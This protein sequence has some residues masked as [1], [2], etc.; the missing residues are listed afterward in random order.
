MPEKHL[1]SPNVK[2]SMPKVAG[3]PATSARILQYASQHAFLAILTHNP[4]RNRKYVILTEPPRE[5]RPV[6][7]H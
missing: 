6:T 4:L 7:M 5:N 2:C 3:C 1:V